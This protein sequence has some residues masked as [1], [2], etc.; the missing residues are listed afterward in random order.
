MKRD[1]NEFQ[2]VSIKNRRSYNF[3][4]ITKFEDFDFD[5]TL[6]GEKSH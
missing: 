2:K 6:I 3:H 1:N 4:D 5:N